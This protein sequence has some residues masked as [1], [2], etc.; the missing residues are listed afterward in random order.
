[1]RTF[2]VA[3]AGTASRFKGFST[4]INAESARAA[5]EEVYQEVLDS[6]YFPQDDGSIRDCNG[7]IIAAAGDDSISYDGGSF[8]ADEPENKWMVVISRH[9][10]PR[11]QAFN[12]YEDDFETTPDDPDDDFLFDSE[13]EAR[14]KMEK[15][16]IVEYCVE[17]VEVWPN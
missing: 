3:Y 13:E 5:V 10:N 11:S 15:M 9:H 6:N 16:A 1:M 4:I 12:R 7:D 14:K 17:A 8:S 2:K